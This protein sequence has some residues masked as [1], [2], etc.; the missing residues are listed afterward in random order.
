MKKKM[1]RYFFTFTKAQE[2]FL[3]KMSNKGWRLIKTTPISFEFESCETSKYLYT[4]ERVYNKTYKELLEYKESLE[5]NGYKTF[6]KNI[7]IN[8]SVGKKRWRPFVSGSA[9]ISS[10]PGTYNKELLIIEKAI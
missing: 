10:N 7:N 4:I 8:F 5:N 9:K 2:N 3:N 1:Y 6:F